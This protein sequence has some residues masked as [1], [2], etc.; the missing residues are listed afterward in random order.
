MNQI[1]KE[2]LNKIRQALHRIRFLEWISYF[3]LGI[4]GGV[5]VC[6]VVSILLLV[7][8]IYYENRIMAGI[9]IA[10]L[11]LSMVAWCV[12]CTNLKG[13]ALLLDEKTKNQ[14]RFVTAL[15]NIEKEDAISALQREDTLARSREMEMKKIFPACTR[16]FIPNKKYHKK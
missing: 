11:I 4:L 9:M 12:K 13:A 1:K 16:I 3:T 14:E 10:F 2:I 6:V 5:G 7:L 15:E 8:P